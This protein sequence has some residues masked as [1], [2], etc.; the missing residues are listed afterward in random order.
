MF[1]LK[2]F[3][4]WGSLFAMSMLLC[5]HALAD[6]NFGDPA[7][8]VQPPDLSDKGLDVNATEPIILADDFR[9]T[10]TGPI[11]DI[12]IWGSWLNDS[13]RISAFHLSIHADIPADPNRPSM[14]GAELWSR[15]FS[16]GQFTIRTFATANEQFFD[17]KSNTILGPDTQVLQY[18][19]LIPESAAFV[20]TNG[21]IY[22]LDVQAVANVPEGG[23]LGWKTSSQH[24]NDNAVWGETS[25]SGGPITW[26]E[27]IDPRDGH[28]LDL[29][30]A[31]TTVP[32]PSGLLLLGMGAAGLVGVMVR[33]RCRR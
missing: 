23:L 21:T 12:H 20:Q 18:N 17:P 2:Q 24:F 11:T 19:F 30:F 1:T 28:S 7:K 16:P 8:W 27:L 9:C 33:R 29:S 25:A 31:L 10:Q 32:E 26:R 3:L 15:D 13:T 22:W 5:G 6:W 14:P 4:R